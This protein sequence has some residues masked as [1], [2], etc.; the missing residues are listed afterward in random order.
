M[1]K[2]MTTAM[3]LTASMILVAC[4]E[5]AEEAA[6][7]EEVATEVVE[8]PAADAA[9]TDPAAAESAD[10]MA[11]EEAAPTAEEMMDAKPDDKTGPPDRK[12]N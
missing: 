6:P 4:G 12:T 9:A 3:L 7:V 5:K 8:E 10:A 1:R 11:G 2:L